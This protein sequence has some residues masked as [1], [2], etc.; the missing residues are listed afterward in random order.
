[1]SIA[2][3]PDT[4]TTPSRVDFEAIYR[5][6][7]PMIYRTAYAVTRNRHDA[8]DVLQSVFLKL[9]RR[10]SAKSPENKVKLVAIPARKSCPESLILSRIGTNSGGVG[11]QLTRN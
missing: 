3:V 5:E 4:A 8:D 1:M 6:Y 7:S 9:I 2:T 11:L 10:E